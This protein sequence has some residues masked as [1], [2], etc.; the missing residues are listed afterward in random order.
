MSV[1]GGVLQRAGA[2]QFIKFCIVGATSFTIDVGISWIL[3]FQVH[4]WWVLARTISF[5][6]AVTNGFFWN[7]RRTFRAKGQRRQ[8]DQYAMFFAVNIV[9]LLLNL[10]IMKGVFFA[11]TGRWQGQHPTKGV[12]L[13]AVILAT[14]VVTFWN[15][16]ANKHWTFRRTRPA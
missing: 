14:L 10:A 5:S 6:L 12:W 3:T 15:F 13:I 11:V 16:F 9:G 4:L 1:A 2:R 8:Q 7:Q